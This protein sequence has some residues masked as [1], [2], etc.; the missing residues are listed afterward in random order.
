M[1]ESYLT[2]YFETTQEKINDYLTVDEFSN[3]MFHGQE[4]CGFIFDFVNYITGTD[5]VYFHIYQQLKKKILYAHH[6]IVIGNSIDNLVLTES[7]S[8]ESDSDIIVN[9]P[10]TSAAKIRREVE[11]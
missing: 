11:I 3:M 4:M 8:E 1:W 10:K 5:N 7:E 9:S 6:S 2:S